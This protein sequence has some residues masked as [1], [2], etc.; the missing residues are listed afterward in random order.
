M[1]QNGSGGIVGFGLKY[2]RLVILVVTV[3][4]AFG[5]YALK[6][7]DKNEFP[8]FTVREGLVVAVCPGS[9]ATQME[10]EVLKP[11]EDFIFSYKEVDKTKTNSRCTSGMVIV[12]V[13]L[14][15]N[16]ESTDAFWNK[17]QLGLQGEK[18]KLPSSV[19][20]LEAL[21]DFGDTSALLISLSS[22]DKTY[23]ELQ[24]MLTE[25]RDRLRPIESV[26]QMS[27]YGEQK[28][29]ITIT[30]DNEKL[31]NYGI[32][33]NTLALTM[34]AQGFNTT[35]GEIKG[36]EYTS[37]IYVSRPVGS[38]R[39]IANMI[40]LSTPSGQVV[41]VS[42][43]ATVS[44]E[45]PD[46]SSYITNNGTKSLLLSVSMK[47]GN[48]IVA[49]GK[50]VQ[51][52]LDDFEQTLPADVELFKITD[53]PTVVNSSVMD[54]LR[55]L[56]IAIVAV[57]IVIMI[58]LPIR[59]A[60]IAAATIPVTIFISLGFFYALGIELN[61]VTL[62][63]LIVSLGMIVDNSVVIIDN[64]VEL[65]SEGMD[66]KRAA[67]QS[68]VEF[69]KAIFSATCAISITFFPFLLTLTGMFR[70]FMN[71]FPWA[72]TIILFTSLLIAEILVP[73]LQYKLIKKPIYK[74]EQEAVA[75]GKK[76]FSFFVMLQN[77]Y[78]WLADLCFN[79]PKTT[80]VVGL[81]SVI[82][83][84]WVFME[85]PM[86]LMPIAERNQ[87]AVE[88]YLPTGTPL[89]QTDI[90][91]DSLERILRRDDRVVS[92]ASFHGCSSPRFQTTYAPQVGGPNFAQFIVNTVSQ[93]ATIE[94]LN[95]YTPKFEN[96][97]PEAFCRFKQLSYSNADYPIEVRISGSDFDQLHAV[98][99]TVL[100]AMRDVPGLR[101]VRPNTS[102]PQLG[103]M[104]DTDAAQI[105]R[106]G[107]SNLFLEGTLALRYSGGVPLATVWEGDYG[108]PVVLKSEK[109]DSSRVSELLDEQIPV[110]E[111]AHAPV[112][113]FA[114][115]DPVW[116]YGLIGHYNGVP[117]ITLIA[118][119][120]RNLYPMTLTDNLIKVI[121][122]IEMPDGVTVE[123]GGDYENT[124]EILP[125]IIAALAIAVVII[126]F[127]I[128][129]HYKQV[130]V[131]MILLV[132]LLVCVPGAAFG[133]FVMN[134]PISLTCTLGVIS[135]MGILVRNAII[136][137]DYAEQLQ[138]DDKYGNRDASLES[139]KRRMRPIF[140]TSAA[141]TMGVL[142]MVLS[143]SAL[144]KPMGTVIFFGTP[145]TM[146]FT[147][148]VIP[149][150]LWKF[151]GKS[152]IDPPFGP[153][154]PEFPPVDNGSAAQSQPAT[155]SAPA[156]DVNSSANQSKGNNAMKTTAI[157]LA[158]LLAGGT[159]CAQQTLQAPEILSLEQCR[160]LAVQNN[161]SV[162]IARGNVEAAQAVKDEAFTKYFPT[163]DAT[164]MAFGTNRPIINFD[165]LDVFNLQMIKK[166][167][168]ASV[169]AVQPVFAG[170]RIVNGNRLAS[171][172]V[173]A[174]KLQQ[175][176]AADKARLTAEQYYWQLYTLKS[177]KQ[178]LETVIAMVDTLQYQVGVAVD[179]GVV[180]RNDYLK[181]QLKNNDLHSL[182]VDLDNGITLSRKLLAQYVGMDGTP[183]DIAE[184]ELP[185]EVPDVPY[186][187]Y[188]EPKQALVGT[189]DYQL[190][191]RQVEAARLERKMAVGENMPT[192]GV[193]AGYF[194]DDIINQRNHF[195][196]IF[197]SVNIPISG[198]WGGSHAIK[199]KKIQE[200]NAILEKEN[201]SQMLELGM[202]NAWDD[203]TAAHRKMMIAH[204]SI[205]QS[206]E[207]LRLNRDYYEAGIST[208]TDLLDAQTLYQQSLE[209][210]AE[211]YGNFCFKRATYLDATNQ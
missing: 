115:V 145:L 105:Q 149:V 121:D 205:A 177:K 55:E 35:G 81:L 203:L 101:L 109:S 189:P 152:Q 171:V 52:V 116:D 1:A 197:V 77:G 66:H 167:V 110:L 39:D 19:L 172:G 154:T 178:T 96:Y 51:K 88:I 28:E 166:G 157:A 180:M 99:D 53:Q 64:Y 61:T 82:V 139:A 113:Q 17:F 36:N 181:V 63:C 128:L 182:L 14:D 107:I 208:I 137:I 191:D 122:Q 104:V 111:I 169:V 48:N 129:F 192:V 68:A 7:M 62:A 174:E 86:K 170:G 31:A 193:G 153:P 108:L 37:P 83:G 142:P 138:A 187:I 176:N 100:K 15:D 147:L 3:L 97:F 8:G 160:E 163:V 29:Q 21:T 161:A 106:L 90:V 200:T 12:F 65:I 103:A 24:D 40:V 76:K 26:G 188:L 184:P 146:I 79:W 130:G 38:E 49:M 206:T 211:A 72:I 183:V 91:A 150:M 11:L 195:G 151:S 198:W 5:I 102:T 69:L 143:G 132:S 165:V 144:W 164:G 95:E 41:R 67:Y 209:Q 112:R 20:A 42:D 173:E 74:I 87:F 85:R 168:G 98:A 93:D 30:V 75:S 134:E 158:M 57:V 54:F 185:A 43:I 6:E 148:T 159:I 156:S 210:Y 133:L 117:T 140:L 135:L 201:L 22:K 136:M 92:V 207:N 114:S 84:G 4:V 18:A 179:A 202:T 119:T 60:L 34:M 44:R 124:D 27:V 126:F 33:A 194:Y 196:A 94:V 80:L 58:L 123:Y 190:L 73:F 162:K 56:L 13:E 2:R 32:K 50:E 78:N 45:Y 118:E 120:Q 71:D 9:D 47:D 10:N 46:P 199:K 70:D 131:S 141:A 59:V 155:V 175:Q 204:E 16:I 25:L 125:Q 127:I 89:S 186:D 23:R